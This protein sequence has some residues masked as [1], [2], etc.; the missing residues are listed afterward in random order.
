[1]ID[2]IEK[3]ILLIMSILSNRTEMSCSTISRDTNRHSTPA[4]PDRSQGSRPVLR[5]RQTGLKRARPFGHAWGA[6]SFAPCEGWGTDMI[7]G[8]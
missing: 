6:P 1:M 5:L 2:N 4:I 8:Q 7:P 3:K